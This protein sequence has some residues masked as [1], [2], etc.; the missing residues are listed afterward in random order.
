MQHRVIVTVSVAATGDTNAC[1]VNRGT[2]NTNE[3]N[4]V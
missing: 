1:G 3:I 4:A 2:V